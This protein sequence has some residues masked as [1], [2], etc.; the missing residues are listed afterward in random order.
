[1][2]PADIM[3]GCGNVDGQFT[4]SLL[5]EQGFLQ[6]TSFPVPSQVPS[7]LKKILGIDHLNSEQMLCPVRQ[8]FP[9]GGGGGHISRWIVEVVKTVYLLSDEELPE[10]VTA[11][12]LRALASLRA[13]PTTVT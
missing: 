8:L 1:M 2:A 11:H 4:V 9:G 7:W 10:E 13:R 3:F 5:P 12:E 6:R